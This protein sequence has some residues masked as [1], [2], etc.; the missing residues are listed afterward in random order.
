MGVAG[1]KARAHVQPVEQ[2]NPI[3]VQPCRLVQAHTRHARQTLQ[4][5]GMAWALDAQRSRCVGDV[6]LS[7]QAVFGHE[8]VARGLVQVQAA[9]AF[10][11]VSRGNHGGEDQTCA[12]LAHHHGLQQAQLDHRLVTGQ[13]VA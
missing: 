8:V 5:D 3:A 11:A 13:Q 7:T 6:N 12:P 4:T 2:Q 10:I 1:V 9:L